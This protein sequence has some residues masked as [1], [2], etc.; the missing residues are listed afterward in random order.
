MKGLAKRDNSPLKFVAMSKRKQTTLTSPFSKRDA[1]GK[2]MI[3]A[4]M[5]TDITV[6]VPV[7][8]FPTLKVMVNQ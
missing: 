3:F 7:C 2:L 8:Q 6:V 5:Q 1:Q 4:K